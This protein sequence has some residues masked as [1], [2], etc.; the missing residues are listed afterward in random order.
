MSRQSIRKELLGRWFALSDA[1]QLFLRRA[2]DIDRTL[3]HSEGL[4]KILPLMNWREVGADC[5]FS[6]AASDELVNTLA[7]Q[8]IVLIIDAGLHR[9]GL[10]AGY[11]VDEIDAAQRERWVNLTVAA[12]GVV[13]VLLYIAWML[14]WTAA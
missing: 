13:P 9:F 2:R 3:P 7:A 6:E 8:K 10:I 5:G 11:L 4:S 12:L 1:Q 14:Y